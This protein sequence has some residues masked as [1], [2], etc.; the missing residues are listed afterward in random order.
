SRFTRE[1][2]RLQEIELRPTGR[3]RRRGDTGRPDPGSTG[4]RAEVGR[5]T[6]AAVPV[7]SRVGRAVGGIG[8]VEAD[9]LRGADG[10]RAGRGGIDGEDLPGRIGDEDGR[11]RVGLALLDVQDRA[12]YDAGK[13]E[14]EHERGRSE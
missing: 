4:N 7:D 14:H 6:P 1:L 10:R 12:T 11:R 8:R 9:V 13:S 5:P 3:R 2:D